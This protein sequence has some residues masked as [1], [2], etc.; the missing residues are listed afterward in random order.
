MG[1]SMTN[2]PWHHACEPDALHAT[3]HRQTESSN[4]RLLMPMPSVITIDGP[5]ASGKS[6]LGDLLAQRLGYTYFDTGVLYRALTYLALIH[7]VALD[8][9]DD[10]VALAER[11]PVEVLP[12]TVV[13]GRQ[14]TVLAGGDDITWALRSGDVERHVSQVSM[15]QAVRDA[16][17]DRQRTIGK[18][19]RVVMVGRDIGSVV[20]PDADFKVFIDASLDERARRRHADLLH[21]GRS[22]SLD[23]VRN[24]LERR[25]LQD[26]GNTFHPPDAFTLTTDGLSPADEVELLLAALHQRA[27]S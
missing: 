16:L 1:E 19:G 15:Y 25:D 20:M 8:A 7:N 26:R 13:D 4:I 12:P 17:R 21:Q 5:A 3:M 2:G 18:R 10:L 23:A 24:D 22:T 27:I 6:T 9:V 11:T 14:Y